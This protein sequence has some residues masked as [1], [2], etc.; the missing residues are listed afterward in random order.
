MFA[1][2]K[3][4][5]SLNQGIKLGWETLKSNIPILLIGFSLVGFVNVLSPTQL[6][7]NLIGPDTG[8]RGLILGEAIG[9]L[10]PGGPYAVFPIIAILYS[11]GAGM[12]PAITIITSWS[13][14]ALIA[15][16]FEIPFMGW[17]FSALRLGMGL[18]LPI[19]A[20]LIVTVIF[21]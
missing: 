10:L 21:R 16:P 5:G 9:M 1:W 6:I 14:L 13:T 3:K 20:G 11:G 18:G 7:Q 12:A 8:L 15:V 2:W 17:R 4:D 19:L